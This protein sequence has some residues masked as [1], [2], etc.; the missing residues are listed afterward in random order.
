MI[1]TPVN[2]KGK[3]SIDGVCEQGAKGNCWTC[4]RERNTGKK[5]I[6]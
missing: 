2:I 5:G 1:N 6:A 4:R 3:T